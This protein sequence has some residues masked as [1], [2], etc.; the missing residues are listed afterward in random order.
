MLP[1]APVHS[2]LVGGAGHENEEVVHDDDDEDGFE[3]V[4]RVRSAITTPGVR[5]AGGMKMFHTHIQAHI[6]V[7]HTQREEEGK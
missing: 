6:L 2:V 7:T 3:G 1:A 4:F 5:W